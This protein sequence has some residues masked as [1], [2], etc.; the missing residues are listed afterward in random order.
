[1]PFL[2]SLRGRYTSFAT[3]GLCLFAI[4]L[5]LGFASMCLGQAQNTGTVA[6]NV[7]DSQHIIV[8]GA[9][10]TLTSEERGNVYRT[11]SN[12]QGEFTFN[13]IPVGTYTLNVTA[14]TFSTF[15]SR[16][17]AVDSDT[18][19]RIDAE[20]KP[21]A[22]DAQVEVTADAATVDTQS[23]TIEQ[24]LDN[25]LV[26]NLPIDGNNVV[27][28]A[29][30]LPG[31]TDVSAPT[32]FTDENGGATFS[33]N[34]A[35]NNS[36]LFLFDG[37]LWNNLYLNTGINY[38]N[39]AVLQ[40]VSVQL[41]NFSAQYGRNS[42]SVYN[43]VS[44]SGSN[45]VHGQ[46]FFHYEDSIFN[47]QN[48]FSKTKP[49]QHTY[50]FGGAVGGPIKRD[51][52]FYELEY[53]S[54]IGFSAVQANAET[55]SPAEEGLN[56][57]GTPRPCTSAQF[58]GFSQCASFAGDAANPSLIPTL[59]FDPAIQFSISSGKTIAAT[60]I[61]Q[62]NSTWVA[63]GNTLP[64]GGNSPCV[65]L[66]QSLGS[67]NTTTYM[68]NAEVPS[69][70]FDPV[71]QN[72]IAHNYIPTPNT[73]LGKSQYLYSS[74]QAAKP[75]HE[76]GGFARVD[77]N[78]SQRNAMDAT[79]YKTENSDIASNGGANADTGVPTYELDEN[80]A[81]ITAA[82]L[83]ERFTVTPNMVNEAKLG[84]KRYEYGVT[85][86]DSTTLQTLGSQFVYPGYQSLPTININTRFTLGSAS[87]AH[88][89]SVSQDIE[90]IDNLTWVHG[91]HNIQIGTD[92][93]R[94]QYLNQRTNVGRFNFY[95]NP[96]YT[97]AQAADFIMGLIYS[98]SVGNGQTIAGIQ[99]ALY[100]YVEDTWRATSRLT[101]NLGIRYELPWMW[102]QPDGQAATFVR[103]YQST[104]FPN[105]PA[106]YAFVGDPGVPRSL[107]KTDYT[108]VS[109]RVGIAYDVFGNGRTAI[110]AGFGTFYDAIPA[111]VV[112]LSAPFA[113]NATYQT[114]DG[115]LTNPLAG[116]NPI[117]ADFTPGGASFPTPY[118]ITYPDQ[119]FRNA[120]TI[121]ANLGF[122]QQIGKG[123]ILEANYLGRFSRHLSM[124]VDQNE[125]I[126]D[127][128]GAYFAANPTLYCPAT[129]SSLL[130]TSS[131]LSRIRY[132]GFNYGGSGVI[133]IL[134]EATANYNALQIVLRQRMVKG[135]SMLANYTYA[136]T[137]DEQSKP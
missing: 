85:P 61:N 77:Y 36:N 133:D 92:Y 63:A 95:G 20:M 7:V 45:S 88:T 103:G 59:I 108:N 135:I 109:P 38:P 32:T 98:E 121:G 105:A 67:A 73:Q 104:V 18:R 80:A 122:Q 4:V 34:G 83:G 44:K 48:Y 136:K 116:K 126:M 90:F 79:F 87:T 3:C 117:P 50:Q 28:M 132:P 97:N 119:N 41:N 72:I 60:A 106:N 22:V 91:R 127:C 124:P 1:M 74:A 112:G 52:A 29:A 75:Q 21:G 31:V 123:T 115:S 102:Y 33:A 24:V 113:Y 68:P 11:T 35:R 56:P 40:Q 130:S 129:P 55:L 47:A 8:P 114:P 71:V 78:L 14:P 134:S 131:Y 110:R 69:I 94:L 86:S 107:V 66:L 99:H 46:A 65:S 30:L 57:D 12:E 51:K 96:G 82:S 100:S 43:V 84:Y 101:L 58:A 15:V 26:E 19:L 93:L 118:S 120:Y 70:C 89:H 13:S 42:G 6:G 81:Y 111:T 27:S 53:Q 62:L 17:V 64:P 49:P 5:L 9:A 137:M 125:A 10:V 128:T 2:C 39:H 76:Y 54:L 16:H 37:L 25:N 23:G